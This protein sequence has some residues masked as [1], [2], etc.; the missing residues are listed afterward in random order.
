MMHVDELTSPPVVNEFYLVDCVLD[1]ENWVPILGNAH[2]DKIIDI[3]EWHYHIDLR[4]SS[5]IQL[6][7]SS[8][9]QTRNSIN[10]WEKTNRK[11]LPQKCVRLRTKPVNL[12]DLLIDL[13][14]YDKIKNNRCPHKGTYLGNQVP[15]GC[16]LT[17]PAHGLKWDKETGCCVK[18][19]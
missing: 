7:L 18:G 2:N 10:E 1:G 16:I 9:N 6:L 14:E 17:C 15:Q 11:V 19:D 3:N 12:K 8:P 4:F 5:T 13:Y